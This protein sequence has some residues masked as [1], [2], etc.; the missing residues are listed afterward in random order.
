MNLWILFYIIFLFNKAKKVKQ[1]KKISY[2]VNL[3]E[4]GTKSSIDKIMNDLN[5]QMTLAESKFIDYALGK[6]E[7]TEGMDTMTYYLF[8]GTQVQRNYC[9]LYFG[10]QGEYLLI[11]KAFDKGL[12][13]AK[14]AF[15]R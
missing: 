9:A 10:R 3:A 13:D 2:Y 7:S 6:I 11:R 15:S 12:L 5:R 1:I 14:Q 8:H 4:I